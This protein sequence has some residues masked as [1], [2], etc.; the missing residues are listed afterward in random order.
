MKFYIL[1]DDITIIKVLKNIIEER[2]L[3]EVIGYTTNS[4]E[5]IQDILLKKPDIVLIDLLMPDKDGI[6]IVNEIKSSNLDISFI[7]ISQVSSK[8]MVGEA[9][10]SEIEFFISKP[11]NIIEVTN[12]IKKVSEKIYVNR[13]LLKIKDMFQFAENS[14]YN[15]KN[16]TRMQKIK[17]ILN[18]MGV[19]G[20]N[21]GRDILKICEY[22]IDKE[23]KR[24]NYTINEICELLDENA[25]SMQQRIR[26]TIGRALINIASIGIE[27]YM[28][29][30]FVEYSNSLFNFEEVKAEMD[31]IRGKKT[32]GGKIN[33]KK[34]ITGLL[35]QSEL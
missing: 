6:D 15:Q 14:T 30:I 32:S 26:R 11:I 1:D 35:T 2:D 3:G 24:L 21:G 29:E 33:I 22:V 13:T 20:E 17:T 16:D 18:K 10:N 23:E 25:R 34:F 31:Y 7:M 19:L 4:Q 5:S 8:H 28:N 27:D 9:Y 12:V